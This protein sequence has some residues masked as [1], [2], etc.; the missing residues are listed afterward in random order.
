MHVLQT[1]EFFHVK[2]FWKARMND[3]GGSKEFVHHFVARISVQSLSLKKRLKISAL[4]SQCFKITQK[5]LILQ[6]CER[7]EL[8]FFDN[9]S[10]KNLE[11]LNPFWRKNSNILKNIY[12]NF[13]AKNHFRICRFILAQKLLI[14]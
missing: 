5:S 8:F 4:L 1:I 13:R 12:L 3:G 11:Y 9:S 2:S 14:F 7:S 10:A 6:L